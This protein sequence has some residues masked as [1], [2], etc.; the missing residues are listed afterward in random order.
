MVITKN[1]LYREGERLATGLGWFSIA[2]GLSEVLAPNKVAELIGVPDRD[3]TES[4]LRYYGFREIAA[5]VGILS[6]EDPTP[7]V[8]ARIAGDM[9]DL[10]SLTTALASPNSDKGKVASATAAVLGVTALDVLCAQKLSSVPSREEILDRKEP[11]RVHVIETVAINRSP[12][13][14]YQ[15]WRNLENL[16]R[17]MSHLKSV[18]MIGDNRSHWIVRG[19]MGRE[20]AWDAEMTDD[21]PN[22]LL[23]WRSI[24][25]DI[26]TTGRV[27][28]ERAAG[29]RGTIVRVELVYA[30]P[31]GTVGATLAKLFVSEPGQQV[32]GDL[33]RLKQVMETG[34]VIHSEASIHR[35]P[36]PAMPPTDEE[37]A[38]V[39]F[40]RQP[41]L[42]A[43]R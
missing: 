5:G 36:H 9:L 22:S 42:A 6:Q 28:F 20:I 31:L 19:P 12:S 18:R 43:E 1:E 40:N 2:L 3:S 24:G 26:E 39:G 7:W 27:S 38:A 8:Y 29:D 37:L 41:A 13:E 23:A 4:T 17:F 25:G 34:E 14:V 35:G 32:K 15:F 16:P 11:G 33:R 21:A 10:A 30:P